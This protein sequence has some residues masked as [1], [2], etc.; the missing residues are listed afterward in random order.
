VSASAFG[1]GRVGTPSTS[2]V[3]ITDKLWQRATLIACPW[4]PDGGCGFA[5]HGTYRR[6]KPADTY[7]ARWYC[8]TA[9]HTVSALPDF[10]ASHRSGTL[11]ECEAVLCTVESA[12]SIESACWDLRNE[13]ELPGVLR[14]VARLL[15]DIYRALSAI[16]GLFPLLI[17]CEPNVTD[18]S[19]LLDTPSVLMQLRSIASQFLP[20]LPTP[21]GFNPSRDTRQKSQ[22]PFQHRVGRDPPVAF[23]ETVH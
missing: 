19:V 8:P 5:R 16:K 18:F 2:E 23:V 12:A 17:T 10:L 13:I 7:V 1:A 6:V 3:Y 14:Y 4:H 11:D 20:Q 21:L 15:R 22:Q 9:R